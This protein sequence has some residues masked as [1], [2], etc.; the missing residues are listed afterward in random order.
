MNPAIS[1]LM[2]RSSMVELK[3][4]RI[5]DALSAVFKDDPA[6]S[7]FWTLFAEAERYHSLILQLQKHLVDCRMV[8]PERIDDWRGDV[9]TMIAYLDG[10]LQRLEGG[11]WRPTVAEA[12]ALADHIENQVVEAQSHS[13]KMV[14]R[15]A[16]GDLVYRLHEEDLRHRDKLNEARSRFDPSFASPSVSEP[17]SA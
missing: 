16:I 7:S 2:D 1:E 11:A 10:Q 17:D 6:L 12:F 4:A 8:P 9:E 14:D 3:V 13:F 15:S 5:Y